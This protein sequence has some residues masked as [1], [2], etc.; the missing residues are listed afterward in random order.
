VPTGQAPGHMLLGEDL[1]AEIHGLRQG[2]LTVHRDLRSEDC[3]IPRA[4]SAFPNYIAESSVLLG[5]CLAK[6]ANTRGRHF[7]ASSSYPT[8]SWVVVIRCLVGG[9]RPI[10][11][12]RIFGR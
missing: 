3:M 6:L 10:E 4:P 12:Y 5:A 9:V 11:V 8:R 7:Q 1:E 2:A